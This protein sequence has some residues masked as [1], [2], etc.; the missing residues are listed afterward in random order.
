MTRRSL[1][2]FLLAVAGVGGAFYARAEFPRAFSILSLD[3][4]MDRTA[5]LAAAERLSIER[6]WSPGADARTA[7]LFDFD[8]RAQT[9]IELE[10]GGAEVFKQAV[11]DGIHHAYRWKV[12][13]FAAE[14]IGETTVEFAPDGTPLGFEE[15]V[16]E[17]AAGPALGR[18]TA[19]QLAEQTATAQWAVDLADYTPIEAAGE[20]R[21]NG[22][23][24]HTFVYEAVD[25]PL[26][27]GRLRLRVVVT[28]DQVTKLERFLHVPEAFERSYDEMRSSNEAIAEGATAAM[29]VLY[30]VF[31]LGLGLIVML[32][33]KQLDWR[34]AAVVGV[35]FGLL[36]MAGV[37]NGMPFL[38]LG[39]DTSMPVSV[40]VLLQLALV[41]VAGV[42]TFLQVGLSAAAAESLTRA[43]FPSGPQTWRVW[44]REAGSSKETLGWTLLGYLLIGVF[45]AYMVTF[46]GL[47]REWEGWWSPTDLLVQ[48]NLFATYFPWLSP[49]AGAL[50][51]GFWEECLFRAVP[52]AGAALLGDRFGRRKLWIGT[53]FVIQALVF[54]AAHA[55]YP[56]QPAYA[57]LVELILPSF[58]FGWVY[59]R[60]GLLPGIILHAGYDLVLMAMPVFVAE[61]SGIWFDRTMVVAVGLVPLGIVL[62]RRV[63][64]GAWSSFPDSLRN[65]G[66]SASPPR[67]VAARAAQ[68]A[69]PTGLPASLLPLMALAGL[70]AWAVTSD[71]SP[72]MHPVTATRTEAETLAQEALAQQGVNLGPEWKVLSSAVDGTDTEHRFVWETAGDST[73]RA[74]LGDALPVPQWRVRFARFEGDV[75]DRAEEWVVQIIGGGTVDRV[76]HT[77][78]EGRAGTRLEEEEVRARV[79]SALGAW[80][81]APAGSLEPVSVEPDRHPERTDW[82][83]TYADRSVSLPEGEIRV[84]ADLLGDEVTYLRR[85]VQVPEEW[86]RDWQ[87]RSM[88]ALLPV[89][90]AGLSLGLLLLIALGMGVVRTARGQ[91]DRHVT[92][93]VGLIL[94]IASL[95][96]TYNGWAS[97][98]FGYQTTR[99]WPLQFWSSVGWGVFGAMLGAG[100]LA[101]ILG[102]LLPRTEVSR[103]YPAATWL[104]IGAVMAGLQA[105]FSWFSQ[106]MPGL[107]VGAIEQGWPVLG[108]VTSEPPS[109]LWGIALATVVFSFGNRI[110]GRWPS[111]WLPWFIVFGAV[112]GLM[113]GGV[114]GIAWPAVALAVVVTPGLAWVI[115]RIGVGVLVPASLAL[116]ALKGLPPAWRWGSERL[117]GL[118]IGLVAAWFTLQ[119]VW[120]YGMAARPAEEVL[121]DSI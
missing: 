46:Y 90:A 83:V 59:L 58:L 22:R 66:W 89:G 115:R 21:P 9:F 39:Y 97:T 14:E 55:N 36:A 86:S 65:A 51:A 63:Q 69:Q 106:G 52:L 70:A 23:V 17:D 61:S 54:A 120:R 68:A 15:K 29:L 121:Q 81:G 5:A 103:R 112:A 114:D 49:V 78:P 27:A 6:E 20:T 34:P 99:P 88:Y 33:R 98:P 64:A 2:W 40:F 56:A 25:Q 13:R 12:R 37:A 4:R 3:L 111:L 48:P 28:G 117:V 32:R 95:I 109:L 72:P 104:G 100:A 10:G 119:I 116:A 102:T 62:W 76:R 60:H 1:L 79:D 118:A 77:L 44:S 85:F 91:S 110:G 45:L 105:T 16:A 31:G 42:A 96:G 41:V 71:W 107:A 30:G 92:A 74:L 19:R 82:T 38:W 43:A 26:G 93:M 50:Q 57:R 8:A 84:A 75:A 11:R 47:S 73:F 67:P 113:V 53:A 87:R 80:V 24:D 108:Q 101:M 94:L 7:V 35:L 18:D